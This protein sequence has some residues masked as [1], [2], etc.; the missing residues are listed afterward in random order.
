MFVVI[1]SATTVIVVVVLL[2]LPELCLSVSVSLSVLH[3]TGM[4]L[5]DRTVIV[6][7]VYLNHCQSGL[8]RLPIRKSVSVSATTC[9]LKVVGNSHCMPIS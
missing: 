3:S 4:A 1:F 5:I 6:V 8:Y 2:A 9:C 7:L